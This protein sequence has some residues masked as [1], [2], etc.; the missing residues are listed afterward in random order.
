MWRNI[1]ERMRNRVPVN[2]F[3][4]GLQSLHDIDDDAFHWL[5]T[6]VTC[7]W[8]DYGIGT[9]HYNWPMPVQESQ[10]FSTYTSARDCTDSEHLPSTCEME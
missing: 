7:T 3:E 2:K 4:G 9:L 1:A 5:E 10:A 8:K 6:T